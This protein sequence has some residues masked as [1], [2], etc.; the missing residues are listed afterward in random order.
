MTFW[1]Q[2]D[3]FNLQIFLEESFALQLSV[4]Y[5]D[6]CS[7]LDRTEMKPSKIK[8]STLLNIQ[9]QNVDQT[10]LFPNL[11]SNLS[12]NVNYEFAVNFTLWTE[13][14]SEY[15]NIKTDLHN[16]TSLKKKLVQKL[17]VFNTTLSTGISQILLQENCSFFLTIQ[18]MLVMIIPIC[19]VMTWWHFIALA[20]SM[21]RLFL[22]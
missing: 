17:S 8:H 2:W 5:A 6:W 19:I 7:A 4:S 16:L 18:M 12:L 11:N 13:H 21:W 3:N 22:K 15:L 10:W 14:I 9:I 20:H 1:T